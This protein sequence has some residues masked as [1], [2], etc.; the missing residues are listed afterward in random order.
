MER[1]TLRDLYAHTQYRVRLTRGGHAVIRVGQ[2]L[3]QALMEALPSMDIPWAF[4]TAWNPRS[5]QLPALANRARQRE[6]LA[7]LRTQSAILKAAVGV[8]DDARWGEPSVFVAGL[9]FDR[10]DALMQ[11]FCQH[12]IVRGMGA[13]PAELHWLD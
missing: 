7:A 13:Q 11:P 1:I 4:V 5:R 6:L 10:V 2:A 8:A 12:A 9:P 3:P